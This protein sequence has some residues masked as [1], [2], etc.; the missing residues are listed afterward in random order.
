MGSAKNDAYLVSRC[1]F[2]LK[3]DRFQRESSGLQQTHYK[4]IERIYRQEGLQVRRRQRK[5][6][7]TVARTPLE[8]TR[9]NQVWAMDFVHDAAQVHLVSIVMSAIDSANC[10][11][12]IRQYLDQ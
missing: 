4:R 8:Q 3:L 2:P 1:G 12:G 7:A 11:S 6:M 9:S 5:K 10:S